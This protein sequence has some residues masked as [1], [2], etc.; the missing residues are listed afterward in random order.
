MAAHGSPVGVVSRARC[1]QGLVVDCL[2]PLCL[3]FFICVMKMMLAMVRV[4]LS[5]QQAIMK[6]K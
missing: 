1:C 2:T 5:R 4:I 3:E 6:I